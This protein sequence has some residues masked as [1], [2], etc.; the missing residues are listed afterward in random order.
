MPRRGFTSLEMLASIGI[1]AAA[2]LVML[3][4]SGLRHSLLVRASA[5]TLAGTFS[6]YRSMAG[7]SN[8]VRVKLVFRPP[9]GPYREIHPS[10]DGAAKEPQKLPGGV[11]LVDVHSLF[12]QHD[13][14]KPELWIDQNGLPVDDK[15]NRL[16]SQKPLTLLLASDRS[17]K[18][19]YLEFTEK[20]E[21]VVR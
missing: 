20:G 16:K 2:L 7:E 15:G 6:Q 4:A 11:Y 19:A 12:R 18:V 1:M 10:I 8:D 14:D 13:P 3:E 9:G 5:K 21:V 17:Q